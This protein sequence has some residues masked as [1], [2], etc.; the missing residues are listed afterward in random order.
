MCVCGEW[1]HRPHAFLT[2]VMEMSPTCKADSR[3]QT[4]TKFLVFYEIPCLLRNHKFH[5]HEHNNPPSDSILTY[6][7]LV[8]ICSSCFSKDHFNIIPSP[9]LGVTRIM[10]F[11][12]LLTK[13]HTHFS[14]IPRP[15][16][17]PP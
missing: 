15:S 6:T 4:F 9:T 11:Q 14:F 16:Y 8:R 13:L 5:F 1:T 17:P 7:N 3:S 2:N 12:T 10:F